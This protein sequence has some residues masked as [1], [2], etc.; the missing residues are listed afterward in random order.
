MEGNEVMLPEELW[1]LLRAGTNAQV[2]RRVYVYL[3][4]HFLPVEGTD[5]RL[6]EN[7]LSLLRPHLLKSASVITVAVP[8]LDERWYYSRTKGWGR[9]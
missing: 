3:D 4:G 9:Y 7:V 1:G 8:Y 2:R 6:T 5:Y